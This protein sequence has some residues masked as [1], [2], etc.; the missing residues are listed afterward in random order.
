[1]DNN[2]N[3]KGKIDS[4]EIKKNSYANSDAD[5]VMKALAHAIEKNSAVGSA[6]ACVVAIKGDKLNLLHL[7]DSRVIVVRDGRIIGRTA[8]QQPYFN[9]PY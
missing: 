2:K 9:R 1:M 5:G 6:T 3:T 4:T 7:C 8:E